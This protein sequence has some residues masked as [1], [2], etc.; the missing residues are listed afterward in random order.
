MKLHK[1]VSTSAI[2]FGTL[3]LWPLS[4]ACEELL[5]PANFNLKVVTTEI[6]HTSTLCATPEGNIAAL[7]PK[8]GT[9]SV[10]VVLK[11]LVPSS[12]TV[13]LPE[14][15]FTAVFGEPGQSKKDFAGAEAMCVTSE[16]LITATDAI[17]QYSFHP[18][19]IS[20]TL[21]FAIPEEVTR[22]QVTYPAV[23][24]GLAVLGTGTAGLR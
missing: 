16:V 6:S 7:S 22:F 1:S 8:A 4:A 18:G 10:K 21:L 3:C 23:A 9:K 2:I 12:G 20:I 15:A 5:N 13:L 14:G 24:A 19:P 11:G 17:R